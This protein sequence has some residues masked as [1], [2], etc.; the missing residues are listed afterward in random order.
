MD[1]FVLSFIKKYILSIDNVK[2]TELGTR[3]MMVNCF[4]AHS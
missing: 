2:G 4:L 3:D 1:S